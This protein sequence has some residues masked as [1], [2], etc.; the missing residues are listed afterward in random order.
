MSDYCVGCT[1]N[2]P[3]CDRKVWY[4]A[5]CPKCGWKGCSQDCSSGTF[6]DEC[7]CPE[8]GAECDTLK[9]ADV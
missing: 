4:P 1:F 6:G 9:F 3:K 8:C 5:E 2:H 7:A